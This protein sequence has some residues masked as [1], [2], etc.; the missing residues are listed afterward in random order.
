MYKIRFHGRGGQ[1]AVVASK[2]LAEAYFRQGFHVQ[3]FPAFGME[4][5][6][7]PV[8]AFVRADRAPILRRG[9]I[10]DPTTVIALDPALLDMIDITRAL[11]HEGTILINHSRPPGELKLGEGFNLATVDAGRIAVKHGIGSRLA[12]IVNTIVLG[13]FARLNMGVD[14]GHILAAIEAGVPSKPEANVAAAKEAFD[15]V[16]IR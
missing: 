14:L 7:A 3:A 11:S 13:A 6:G 1:G 9:E 10:L 8:A 16:L 5:R 15:S 4:R 2:I 12:P